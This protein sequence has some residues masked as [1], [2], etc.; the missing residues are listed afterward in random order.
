MGL[1][2]QTVSAI[3][4]TALFCA[5]GCAIAQPYGADERGSS[6]SPSAAS[7]DSDVAPSDPSRGD[8]S[9]AA[10]TEAASLVDAQA[11]SGPCAA[12]TAS[13]TVGGSSCTAAT[14]LLSDGASATLTDS[15]P[16][17]TG[18]VTVICVAGKLTYSGAVCEPPKVFDVNSPTGC[19]NG[20]C[21]GVIGGQCGQPDPTKATAF[22]VFK[23]YAA[24]TTF[25][26]GPGVVN[27]RQ[28]SAD[29]TG[30]FTNANASCNIILTS[31]TCR[32]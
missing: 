29:G 10:T 32:H 21:K 30:C 6:K 8:P 28:C 15:T 20:Y 25:E 17:D 13:W 27:A 22:C 19:I 3:S 31:V 5:A 2:S 7:L 11:P 24:Y 23:G 14:S 18:S 4:V 26:T 16:D 9:A 1:V 12:Q